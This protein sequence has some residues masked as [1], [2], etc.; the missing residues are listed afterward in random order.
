MKHLYY[1]E[2]IISSSLLSPQLHPNLKVN[3]K[4]D[5][6][7]EK[8]GIVL[9]EFLYILKLPNKEIASLFPHFLFV[10]LLHVIQIYCYLLKHNA[11]LGSI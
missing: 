6:E 4:I 7:G 8:G 2:C 9:A 10:L 11:I 5:F 1:L 3:R